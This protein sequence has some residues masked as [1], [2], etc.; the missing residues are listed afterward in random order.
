MKSLK[1]FL[2]LASCLI[3]SN[4]VFAATWQVTQHYSGHKIIQWIWV[5]KDGQSHWKSQSGSYDGNFQFI[6]SSGNS[7]EI[8]GQINF[9]G[10]HGLTSLSCYYDGILTSQTVNGKVRC[11]DESTQKETVDDWSATISP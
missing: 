2:A 9:P 4:A 6:H 1:T 11:T 5:I 7:L 10:N 3:F 8:N